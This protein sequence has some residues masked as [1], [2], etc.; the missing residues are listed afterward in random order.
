[1]PRCPKCKLQAKQIR[2]EGVPIYSCGSC[3]GHWMSGAR[4]DVI[5]DRRE[6]EMPEAVQQKMM[7]LADASNSTEKLWCLTCGTEMIKESFKYWD[8]IQIDRCPK[9]GGIWLDR[10]ELE[11][12]QIFWEY[13]KDHPEEWEGR[14]LIERKAL[15]NAQWTSRKRDLEERAERSKIAARSIHG[16]GGGLGVLGF[17]WR[18]GGG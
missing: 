14:E 5:L 8:E 10:G 3:G 6:L 4:L 12:C 17:L 7:D 11:K 15:L 1:M 13:A 16:Y 18:R 9:C 2:Y